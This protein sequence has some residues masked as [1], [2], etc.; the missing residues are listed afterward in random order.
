VSTIRL[1]SS[2]ANWHII[3]ASNSNS[4]RNSS[5]YSTQKAGLEEKLNAYLYRYRV[6]A[7][8]IFAM[9]GV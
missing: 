8:F 5:L 4:S 1:A 9:H 7:L 3:T 2:N 6:I